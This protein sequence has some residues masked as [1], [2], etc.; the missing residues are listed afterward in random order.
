[1][2][3]IKEMKNEI[4]E[5]YNAIP[6]KQVTVG[7]YIKTIGRKFI[8]LLNTWGDT[9]VEKIEISDFYENHF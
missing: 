2:K 3:T 4:A 6:E 1:M 8:T 5:R 7:I 9:S